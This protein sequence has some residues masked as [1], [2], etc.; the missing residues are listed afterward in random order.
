MF[1]KSNRILAIKIFIGCLFVFSG[2][3]KLFPILAF[4]VQLVSHGF[5]SWLAV[6]V[7]SRL[8]IAFEIFLGLCFFQNNFLKRLFIPAAILLL[9]FFILDMARII[10]L[11]GFAGDCGCF[12]QV[13]V[14]TPLEA[15]IKNIILIAALVYLY[16]LLEKGTGQN[17]LLPVSFLIISF[18]QVFIFFPIKHFQIVTGSDNQT[19]SPVTVTRSQTPNKQQINAPVTKISP[20][21]KNLP[22]IAD[23]TVTAFKDFS[24]GISVNLKKGSRIVAVLN[25]G[26]E[27][28]VEA[29]TQIGKLNNEMKL[30]PVY[31]LLLG[32]E[33]DLPEFLNK[34]KTNFPYKIIDEE[35]FLMLIK[36]SP[37]RVLLLKDGRT[38]EDWNFR[39][40]SISNLKEAVTKM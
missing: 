40:F 13:I 2:L 37:P 27:D 7:L 4:E 3:V 17:W 8:L 9:M 24:G 21:N 35:T 39:T 22:E 32:D 10:I 11:K 31:F 29:A 25:M 19:P 33:K 26:C 34:T 15:I 36:G 14:M 12:G 28:C 16:T 18:V 5:T 23:S 1:S 38:V 6:V 30:P 20:S